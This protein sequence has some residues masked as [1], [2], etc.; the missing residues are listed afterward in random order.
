MRGCRGQFLSSDGG[1][2][3]FVV[4]WQLND[5]D[6]FIRYRL[7]NHASYR[8]SYNVQ[9]GYRM[10]DLCHFQNGGEKDK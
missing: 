4:M 2:L 8:L 5:V 3:V 1:I 9:N 10:V 6:F 7:I